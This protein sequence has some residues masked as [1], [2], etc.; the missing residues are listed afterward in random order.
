MSKIAEGD[1]A[2]VAVAFVAVVAVAVIAVLVAIT[3]IAVMVAVVAVVAVASTTTKRV[4]VAATAS[5]RLESRLPGSLAFICIPYSTPCPGYT[6]L[7]TRYLTLDTLYFEMRRRR[8]WSRCSIR[9]LAPG[10]VVLWMVGSYLRRRKRKRG[11]K[12]H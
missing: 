10:V 8:T 12:D 5:R 9:M 1:I 11:R 2:V 6:L 4:A 7:C 3:I